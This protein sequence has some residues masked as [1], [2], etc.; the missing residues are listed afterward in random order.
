MI[1]AS[2]PEFIFLTTADR[3]VETII[4]APC[5]Q[6][7]SGHY[8]CVSNCYSASRTA[9]TPCYAGVATRSSAIL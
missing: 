2:M 1:T 9:M 8:H 4:V 6:T 5:N 7:V 3:S